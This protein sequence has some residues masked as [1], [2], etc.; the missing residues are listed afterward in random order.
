MLPTA[1]RVKMISSSLTRE[2][3]ENDNT[4]LFVLQYH[5]QLQSGSHCASNAGRKI[6]SF[7]KELQTDLYKETNK[8]NT[9]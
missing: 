1:S 7:P 3:K 4:L 8:T 6:V 5:A 2:K 9:E